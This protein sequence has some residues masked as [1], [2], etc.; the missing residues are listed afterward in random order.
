MPRLLGRVQEVQISS[1]TVRFPYEK[2]IVLFLLL[3]KSYIWYD[4]ISG[5][6]YPEYEEMNLVGDGK[7]SGL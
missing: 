6:L 3:R 7:V 1:E 5:I 2:R 4:S